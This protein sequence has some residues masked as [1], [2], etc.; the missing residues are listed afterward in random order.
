MRTA[1]SAVV[2]FLS[3][4]ALGA[5]ACAGKQ[6]TPPETPATVPPPSE[7]EGTDPPGTTHVVQPG[8]TLWTIADKYD[9]S[10]DEIAEVNGV[11]DPDALAVG[12]TLFIPAPDPMAI[13][14]ARE[15]QRT[16]TS[17]PPP[18]T[19]GT[20]FIWPLDQGVVFSEYG[21]RQGS[22]HDG[23]DMGAPEGT[24]IR[25]AA[26]GE[27]LFAG[28]DK[29]AFGLLV[30]LQHADERVTVYAHNQV[31]LVKEGQRVKQGDVIARVGRTGYAQ[32][33]HLHFEVRQKRKAVDPAPLL[34]PE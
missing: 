20:P 25:A 17:P 7:P 21:P 19:A 14:Q 4:V 11:E 15:R 10:V 13:P 6:Q 29:G 34:P 8:E 31:N 16:D 5:G 24:P 28:D 18:N 23:M 26:D 3:V 22:F 32:S 9:T 1:R 2:A 30:V 33:P 27:V 12:Q